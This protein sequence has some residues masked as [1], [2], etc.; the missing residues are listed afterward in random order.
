MRHWRIH[1]NQSFFIVLKGIL[2]VYLLLFSAGYV[3]TD[4]D[5]SFSEQIQ[6]NPKVTIGV[7]DN[8]I[9]NEQ[10]DK[11]TQSGNVEKT[12]PQ[13]SSEENTEEDSSQAESN[14]PSQE[15]EAC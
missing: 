1:S 4:T 8:E 15:G 5:A 10:S 2:I 13:A 14:K 12:C 11:E 6:T 3:T 7:W 9:V